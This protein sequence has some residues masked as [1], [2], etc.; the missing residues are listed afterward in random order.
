MVLEALHRAGGVDYLVWVARKHPAV[1][2][3]LLIRL[4]PRRE[5]EHVEPPRAII[6]VVSGLPER[7][8]PPALSE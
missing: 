6:K 5:V 8:G 1:F 4:L 7:S 3:R 2:I